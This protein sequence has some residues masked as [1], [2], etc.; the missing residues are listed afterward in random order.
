MRTRLI[1]LLAIALMMF[2]APAAYA[3]EETG[4]VTVVSWRARHAR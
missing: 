3:Q 4:T 1:A 2:L